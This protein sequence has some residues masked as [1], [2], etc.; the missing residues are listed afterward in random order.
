MSAWYFSSWSNNN[1]ND[2]D[3]YKDKTFHEP[4][5][6]SL[7]RFIGRRVLDSPAIASLDFSTGLFYG[8]SCQ[9]YAQPPAILEDRLDC[10]SVWV[11]ITNQSGKGDPTS[12]YTTASIAPRLIDNP[13]PTT[14]AKVVQSLGGVS[15][16]LLLLFT[17]GLTQ[18]FKINAGIFSYAFGFVIYVPFQITKWCDTGWLVCHLCFKPRSHP[19]WY[20]TLQLHRDAVKQQPRLLFFFRSQF[21]FVIK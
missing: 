6:R 18:Y 12:S 5:V 19:H 13:S 8:A 7:N 1:C 2:F 14:N 9:P 21:N 11:F 16:L 3:P 20:Y 17:K 10:L 15:L 4:I